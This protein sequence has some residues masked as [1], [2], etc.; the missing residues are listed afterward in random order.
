MPALNTSKGK[1][2]DR[3]N[4]VIYEKHEAIGVVTLNR[5]EARNALSPEMLC[6]MADA[7]ADAQAD[8]DVRVIILTAVGDQAFCAGGDLG[9]TLPLFTGDRAA[10]SKWGRRLLDESSVCFCI[11]S[12]AD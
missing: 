7:F 5:P 9:L 11:C 6:R 2:V 1:V 10:S 8:A 12:C 3:E 4:V